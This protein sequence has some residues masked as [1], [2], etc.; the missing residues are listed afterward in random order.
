M[1]LSVKTHRSSGWILYLC[2]PPDSGRADIRLTPRPGLILVKYIPIHG[3]TQ[4]VGYRNNSEPWYDEVIRHFWVPESFRTPVCWNHQKHRLACVTRFSV[5]PYWS[6]SPCCR[7]HMDLVGAEV[8]RNARLPVSYSTPVCRNQLEL[9]SPQIPRKTGLSNW[10]EIPG[11]PIYT[12]PCGFGS[13]ETI[14]CWSHPGQDYPGYSCR[15]QT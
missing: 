13:P 6:I 7:S 3:V 10:S 15:N 12:E 1:V 4:T 9:R 11:C 8:T 5:E 14:A 2:D